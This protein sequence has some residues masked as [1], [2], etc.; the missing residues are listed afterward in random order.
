MI[1]NIKKIFKIFDQYQKKNFYILIFLMFISMIL[2]ILGIASLIPLINFF[3]KNDLIYYKEYIDKINLLV[4]FSVLEIISLIIFFVILFFLIKN[5]YIAFYYWFESKTIYKIRFDLGVK[6]F[7]QYINKP[8]SYHIENN[9]SN[10]LSKI[11]H[12]APAF[13]SAMM[14]LASLFSNSILLIGIFLFL[15]I[16]RPLETFLILLIIFFLSFIFFLLIKKKIFNIGKKT[17]EIDRER[18]RVLQESFGGIKEINI[19]NA[20]NQFI[21]LFTKLSDRVANI[22]FIA[23]FFQKVPK[24]WFEVIIILTTFSLLFYNLFFNFNNEKILITLSIFL[25]SSIK[26]LPSVS[27]IL[28]AMQNIKFSENSLINIL[29]DLNADNSNLQNQQ[30]FKNNDVVFK[31]EIKFFNVSFHYS[32]S[33]RLIINNCNISIKKND[34]ICILGETGSGKS[35]FVDLLTSLVS[36]TNGKIL[37]DNVDIS[38]NI[39]SWKNKISY[40]PQ[41]PFLLDASI[42]ENIIF[43][44]SHDYSDEKFNES[45]YKAELNELINRLPN[46]ADSVVGEKGARI[47]GGEKQRIS[48]A[49]AIY[50]DSEIIIF[51][52]STNALDSEME[53]KIMNTIIKFKGIKTIIFITHKNEFLSVFDRKFK[54]ENKTIREF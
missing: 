11:I 33:N 51:D 50:N 16:I 43:Y 18:V 10:L 21:T 52:E 37:L 49:R 20:Q 12:Q 17:E 34:F 41:H 25:I 15:F 8:Y 27:A 53:K 32:N 38:E 44:S 19:Y 31:N 1:S 9:S 24:V 22:G 46:G 3:L 29:N 5:L 7:K 23:S 28:I 47:S 35:T 54:L 14:S 4:N 26:I 36:P 45:L 6:L 13:G 42:K 40:V 48:I 39:Y 2:E 30:I